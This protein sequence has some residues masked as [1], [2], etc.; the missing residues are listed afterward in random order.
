MF[1]RAA[2]TENAK[3]AIKTAIAGVVSMYIAMLFHLPE[4]YWAAI[5]AL[6]VMQSNVGATLS[7]S[8]T[9]LAGTAVGAVVGGAFV[10]L[11]GD[12]I[13]GFALAVAVAYF[14]CFVLRLPDSQ[15]L[16]TVTVA[17]IMLIGRPAAPWTVALHRFIEVSV[18]I[19]IA[20]V[21]S[22][23]LWPN[24]ARRSL[25]EGLAEALVKLGALYQAAVGLPA[26]SD[27]LEV[28]NT[29][30]SD[31]FRKN[32]GLLENALQ[33]AFG[34]MRQRE[35][36]VS[37]AA[38]V[39]RIRRAVETLELAVRDSAPDTYARRF[40]A[41]L[42]QL[43]S[44]IAAAFEWLANS[45]RSGREEPGW[46]DSTAAIAA[47][48]EKAAVARA[49]GAT[50]SYMLDEILRFY[51]LLLS[52]RNLVQELESARGLVTLRFVSK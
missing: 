21:I 45:L 31:V 50:A 9:R 8:R 43:H 38:H 49:S 26:D 33:E 20:L 28:L 41:E 5:S 36:L 11:W 46:P 6:I 7:A 12:S 27:P 1:S 30:V 48:D 39:E 4:G 52:S 34:P 3:Q 51:S 2:A 40:D 18:G 47:L 14:L 29:Q 25:R 10:A 42:E 37:L 44:S 15:R 17:I 16:A 32:A 19:L 13:P 35:S 22:L 24:H 23:T